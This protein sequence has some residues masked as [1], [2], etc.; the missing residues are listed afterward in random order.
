[1]P[2]TAPATPDRAL[3]REIV[4]GI[5]AP[6]TRTANARPSRLPKTASSANAAAA[7]SIPASNPASAAAAMTSKRMTVSRCPGQTSGCCARMRCS[8]PAATRLPARVTAPIR[9][10]RQTVRRANRPASAAWCHAPRAIR[11]DE[12]PPRPLSRAINCGMAMIRTLIA[13]TR[14]A[15]RPIARAIKTSAAL[16]SRLCHNVS[17]M[18]SRALAALSRL[19]SRAV[20]T[21]LIR[22]MPSR[23]RAQSNASAGT[24]SM[25]GM[26]ITCPVFFLKEAQHA[27]GNTEPSGD[28]DHA[29]ND[30]CQAQPAIA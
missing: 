20:L 16:K 6:P 7:V 1:M 21:R 4:I 17:K 14:P 3:S 10:A 12:A 22:W 8:L 2:A 27:F 13:A 19:P 29:Q 15:A 11:A 23:I 30:S 28:I 18:A 9:S 26:R 24:N 25:S 5:S